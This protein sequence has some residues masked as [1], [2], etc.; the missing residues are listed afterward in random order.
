MRRATTA[1][2][3]WIHRLLDH[4]QDAGFEA[5]PRVLGFD[6]RGREMLTFVDGEARRGG[7]RSDGVLVEV[8]RLVRRVHDLTAGTE[9]AEDE[10]CVIHGDLSPRNTIYRD[11]HPVAIIDWDSARP[12]RRMWDVSRACWQFVDPG[13]GSD[14]VEVSRRW[15]LMTEAYGV[16]DTSMLVAEVVDRLDE[17]ADGIE[18]EAVGGSEPHRRLVDLGAPATIRSVRDWVVTHRADLERGLAAH[19][20]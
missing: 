18:A 16:E 20:N 13:P 19:G 4:L 9:L 6:E 8:M 1:A 17:N 7:E 15:R 12:G 2:T 11:G 3:P 14:A 10:E 5:A